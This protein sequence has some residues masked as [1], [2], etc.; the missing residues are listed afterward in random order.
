[1]HSR[2][3][4]SGSSIRYTNQLS[5]TSR[6]REPIERAEQL[7]K[8]VVAVF[9]DY[10]PNWYPRELHDSAKQGLR[11]EGAPM[12]SLLSEFHDLLQKFAPLWYTTQLH[13]KLVTVIRDLRETGST[14]DL[15]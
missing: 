8:E 3:T 10:G 4:Q 6:P 14:H 2:A 1:L 13:E 11:D 5:S 7:L 9:D 12:V 15:S